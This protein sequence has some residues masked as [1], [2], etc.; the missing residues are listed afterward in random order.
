M[1]PPIFFRW[2]SS[3]SKKEINLNLS[4]KGKFLFSVG[5]ISS[6]GGILKIKPLI[7]S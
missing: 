1:L 4:S 5:T 2:A 6:Y 3:W 7:V